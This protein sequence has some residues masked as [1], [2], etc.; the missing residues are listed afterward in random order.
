MFYITKTEGYFELGFS[1]PISIKDGKLDWN[2][3]IRTVAE[4]E[5]QI[6]SDLK[7]TF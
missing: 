7:A 2:G 1:P 3:Q 5:K 4:V 6:A